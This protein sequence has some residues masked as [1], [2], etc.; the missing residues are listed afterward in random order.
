[1]N[2]PFCPFIQGE[3]VNQCVFF[4]DVGLSHKVRWTHCILASKLMD[5]NAEQEQQ[6]EE[7]KDNTNN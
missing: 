3:C 1:M 5:I 2:K 7:I 4:S 6:L